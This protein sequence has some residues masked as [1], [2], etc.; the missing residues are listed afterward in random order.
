MT[1]I[2]TV[3]FGHSSRESGIRRGEHF[4]VTRTDSGKGN[5]DKGGLSKNRSGEAPV[6]GGT[7]D[8]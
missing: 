2:E 7:E 1:A 4:T 8:R 3:R 6:R 5:H